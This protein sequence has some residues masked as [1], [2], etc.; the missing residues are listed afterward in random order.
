VS[1]GVIGIPGI[2]AAEERSF[3]YAPRPPNCGGKEKRRGAPLRMTTRKILAKIMS[4]RDS[5]L[6]R[7]QG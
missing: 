6:R 3:D 4:E 5:S 1:G 2:R 7:G